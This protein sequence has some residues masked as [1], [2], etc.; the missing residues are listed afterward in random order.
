MSAVEADAITDRWIESV[1]P[2]AGQTGIDD[3]ARARL[4]EFRRQGYRL[5]L[6]SD[7][8][9]GY[10]KEFYLGYVFKLPNR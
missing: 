8:P 2:Y 4:K 7:N 3:E 6:P 5:L 9:K 1:L 10:V